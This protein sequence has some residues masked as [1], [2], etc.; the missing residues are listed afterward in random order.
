MLNTAL[1]NLLSG[2]SEVLGILQKV[3]D[4]F[5]VCAFLC[6]LLSCHRSTVTVIYDT[7]V[8]YNRHVLDSHTIIFHGNLVCILLSR[9]VVLIVTIVHGS[10]LSISRESLRFLIAII[11]I[12]RRS[13]TFCRHNLIVSLNLSL[14]VR[15]HS[16][17]L[18]AHKSR[19]IRKLLSCYATSLM[20]T[21][22]LFCIT[23]GFSNF[24]GSHSLLDILSMLQLLLGS[25]NGLALQSLLLHD[26]VRLGSI[27]HLHLLGILQSILCFLNLSIH[28]LLSVLPEVFSK[29]LSTLLRSHFLIVW[30]RS[31]LAVFSHRN[32]CTIGK[33]TGLLRLLLWC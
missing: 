27:V 25:F 5:A 23:H 4:V 15:Q 29:N 18:V 17:A 12:M 11:Y 8:R 21:L 31:S 16:C 7:F 22:N 20:R 10:T 13:E 19:R 1:L 24:L 9:L 14:S 33:L 26:V 6:S 3:V 2:K 32:I 30:R 28:H